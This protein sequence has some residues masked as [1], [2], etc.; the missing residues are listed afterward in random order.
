M[1][2]WEDDQAQETRHGTSVQVGIY[3]IVRKLI[4]ELFFCGHGTYRPET[5]PRT[6]AIIKSLIDDS[7]AKLLG[8]NTTAT[9]IITIHQGTH[10]VQHVPSCSVAYS[11]T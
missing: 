10:Q 4:V 1:L 9:T 8:L 3:A 11:G 5:L 2:D 7:Y 6:W